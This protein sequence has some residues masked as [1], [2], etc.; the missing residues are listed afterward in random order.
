MWKVLFHTNAVNDITEY[1]DNYLEYLLD[2]YS[3]SDVLDVSGIQSKTC[4]GQLNKLYNEIR[5]KIV[6]ELE[7]D[8]LMPLSNTGDAKRISFSLKRRAI[9][10]VYRESQGDKQRYI[11]SIQIVRR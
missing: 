2:I 8:S 10:V 4:L 7:G 1:L 3:D 5:D 11:E 6:T 9:F